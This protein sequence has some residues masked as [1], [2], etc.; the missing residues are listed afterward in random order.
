MSSVFR[1]IIYLI[2]VVSVVMLFS[3]EKEV[4]TSPPEELPP[5][6][7]IFVD[8]NPRNYKIYLDGRFTGRFT[9]DSLPYV[10]EIEHLI[11]LKRKYWLDSSAASLALPGVVQSVYIDFMKNPNVYGNLK[12]F[13]RPEN[14]VVVINDS[15][16][17]IKTPYE[18][19]GLI[20]GIYKI[21]Y[22]LE[23][24]RSIST[25]IAVESNKVKSISLALQDTS[26]WV[27]FNEK[28][29][30]L[31]TRNITALAVDNENRI[32]AGT[33]DHGLVVLKGNKWTLINKNNSALPT[34][35]IRVINVD[36]NNS[37]WVGT[38]KGV[39]EFRENVI[40]RIITKYN[41][42]M[43]VDRINAVDFTN[44]NIIFIASNSGLLKIDGDNMELYPS[45][46]E[47]SERI[48]TAIAVDRLTNQVWVGIKGDIGEYSWVK[49]RIVYN[50]RFS[51][52]FFL[53]AHQ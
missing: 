2:S 25:K 21:E 19:K 6:G 42:P 23:Q 34:D 46:G 44:D 24:H 22:H 32:W 3:C 28:N 26:V 18:L 29:S 27:D 20:P 9:P 10:E 53:A 49:N 45:A 14:A 43:Y 36:N 1:S 33:A 35:S 15:I 16:T 51:S 52:F 12:L 37:V 30:Q 39:V 47:K 40:Q 41:S 5:Q 8:S 13:S 38:F 4:S 7:F 48:A 11:E 17:T 50:N 31:P